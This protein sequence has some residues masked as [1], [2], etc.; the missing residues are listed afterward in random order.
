MPV[1]IR[2]A[3]DVLTPNALFVLAK[4]LSAALEPPERIAPSVWAAK[5]IVVP[6][7]PLAG[8]LID[9]EKT[10]YL[11]EILDFFSPDSPVN[12]VAVRKSAQSAFT[13]LMLAIVGFYIDCAPCNIMLIQ[14]TDSALSEFNSGK[15][16]STIAASA[17]LQKSPRR[18]RAR[19]KGQQP[20]SR[21]F[22]AVGCI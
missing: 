12:E 9:L 20:I 15:L 3:Y 7:G 4:T 21:N 13:T 14:P 8:Q 16:N 10:P 11:K 6:D 5:N 2:N 22:R 1:A 19:A 17:C 18:P